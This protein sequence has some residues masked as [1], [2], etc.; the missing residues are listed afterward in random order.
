MNRVRLTALTLTAL[1]SGLSL[2]ACG[3][4]GEAVAIADDCKPVVDG[5]K[6]VK[7]GKLT[8]AVAEYPPYIST[9][10]GKL[11]GV[12]G[13]VLAEV[14][15]R[16]CLQPDP[17]TQSFSAIIESVKNNSADLTAG[18][19]YINDER[20]QQ[21]EVSNPVYADQMA[22]ISK[23]GG[24]SVS[25]LEGQTVGTTQG[26]LWVED[27]QKVLG[28]QNVRLYATEDAAYQ[29]VKVGRI[30]SAVITYGGGTQLL[31]TYKDKTSKLEVLQPD[32]RVAASVGTPQTAVLVQK[33]NASLVEAVN[34]VVA[35][36]RQEGK[37]AEILTEN[38]LP[39][40]AGDVG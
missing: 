39:E 34:Q 28:K 10:G 30:D 22:V 25:A 21:F 6:T 35:D 24:D 7:K 20:K 23:A 37:L 3:S 13:D 40:S 1:L 17:K 26:Y 5:V 16:L 27:L 2:T 8:M 33:G 29:D 4:G 11:S 9:A 36:L 15:K 31:N 18:N 12:D 38:G 19:W 32:E 14:A